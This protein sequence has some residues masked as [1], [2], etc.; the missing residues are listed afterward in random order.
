MKDDPSSWCEDKVKDD[1]DPVESAR[2]HEVEGVVT[3]DDE[4]SISGKSE[5]ETPVGLSSK[6]RAAQ[7]ERSTLAKQESAAIAWLRWLVLFVFVVIGV[8]F[9]W[10][11]FHLVQKDEERRFQ[12]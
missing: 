7:E 9:A 6:Q 4:H 5:Y 1:K 10:S 12:E 2:N 3:E 8:A 11:T